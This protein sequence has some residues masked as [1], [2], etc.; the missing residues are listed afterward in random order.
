MCVGVWFV[1]AGDLRLS[2]RV[3]DLRWRGEGDFTSRIAGGSGLLQRGWDVCLRGKGGL[4][5]V[6]W[7]GFVFAGY[8][9]LR[10]RVEDWRWHGEGD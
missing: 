1:L 8:F 7:R 5:L 10:E 3:E 2:G 6:L 4:G 9:G